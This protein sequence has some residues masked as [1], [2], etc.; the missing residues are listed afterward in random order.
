MRR[1][2]KI[3]DRVREEL[4]A[5]GVYEWSKNILVLE[6]MQYNINLYAMEA[7][8]GEEMGEKLW[9]GFTVEYGRNLISWLMGLGSLLNEQELKSARMILAENKINDS[10]EQVVSIDSANKNIQQSFFVNI[11]GEDLGQHLWGKLHR[12]HGGNILSFLSKLTSEYRFSIIIEF[13]NCFVCK[14]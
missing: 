11:F 5:S 7:M 1:W 9:Q 4:I 6:K 12:Q 2:K 14:S 8:F 3:P 10:S 13:K